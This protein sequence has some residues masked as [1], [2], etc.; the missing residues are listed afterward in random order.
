MRTCR[1]QQY[2]PETQLVRVT[3]D[4]DG[5]DERD[6]CYDQINSRRPIHEAQDVPL[7]EQPRMIQ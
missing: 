5:H 2:V 4:V 7:I 6:A 1:V 3:L